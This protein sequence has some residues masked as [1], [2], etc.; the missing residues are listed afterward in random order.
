MP[1]KDPRVVAPP[2]PALPTL[3]QSYHPSR[4]NTN[5]GKLTPSMLREAFAAAAQ[6]ALCVRLMEKGTGRREQGTGDR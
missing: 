5:T 1:A 4:Q 3:V 2:D 6:F